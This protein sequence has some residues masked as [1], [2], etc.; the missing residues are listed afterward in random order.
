[1]DTNNVSNIFRY[2]RDKYGKKVS[3]CID[4]GNLQLR[5]LWTI[6]TIGELHSDVLK[7]KS[8]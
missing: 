8:P 7:W 2:L 6:E 3:G 1:M 4:Y 5:K